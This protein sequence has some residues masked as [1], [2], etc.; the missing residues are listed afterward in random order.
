MLLVLSGGA[1]A[2]EFV[3]AV[4][5]TRVLHLVGICPVSL[6]YR[7]CSFSGACGGHCKFS[8]GSVLFLRAVWMVGISALWCETC[9]FYCFQLLLTRK[10]RWLVDGWWMGSRDL[11]HGGTNLA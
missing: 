8:S 11:S 6:W 9:Y 7:F 5:A 1:R 3:C 4:L 2:T 10:V